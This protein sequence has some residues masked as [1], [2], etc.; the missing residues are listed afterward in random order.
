MLALEWLSDES[1]FYTVINRPKHYA[2]AGKCIEPIF[3]H[4]QFFSRVL[5]APIYITGFPPST[6]YYFGG[7]YLSEKHESCC[8]HKKQIS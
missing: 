3:F 5:Q 6:N 4:F 1:S 2:R 7:R 8:R